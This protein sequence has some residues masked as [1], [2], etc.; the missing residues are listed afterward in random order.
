MGWGGIQVLDGCTINSLS[1]HVVGGGEKF[2]FKDCTFQLN[3][4]EG[5]LPTYLCKGWAD[6]TLLNCQIPTDK[7]TYQWTCLLYTSPSPRDRG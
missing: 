4:P 6:I 3:K 5:T 2:L 7:G 1:N